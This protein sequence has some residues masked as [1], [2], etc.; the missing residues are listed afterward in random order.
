VGVQVFLPQVAQTTVRR[1]FAKPSAKTTKYRYGDRLRVRPLVWN[2]PA[3]S[4]GGLNAIVTAGASFENEATRS[5][6]P[7]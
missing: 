6:F 3:Y 7:G 1:N 2:I 5:S 4:K